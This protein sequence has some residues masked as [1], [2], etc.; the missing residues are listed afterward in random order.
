MV[1][2]S[3]GENTKKVSKINSHEKWVDL[4]MMIKQAIDAKKN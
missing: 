1:G 3:I 2:L 4:L